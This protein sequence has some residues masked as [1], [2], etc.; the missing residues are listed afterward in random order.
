M[1]LQTRTSLAYYEGKPAIGIDIVKQS[2]SN[3]V[4]LARDA[5]KALDKLKTSLPK[6]VH[7]NIVSDDSVSIQSTDR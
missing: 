3:T 2:G 6:D 7:V 5:K 1:E 4:Q